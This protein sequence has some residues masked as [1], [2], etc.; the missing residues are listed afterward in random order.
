MIAA[1]TLSCLSQRDL[2]RGLLAGFAWAALF[3]A[4]ITAMQ[5]WQCGG[6]CL[7]EIATTG[8]LSLVCGILAIG[9]LAALGRR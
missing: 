5:A 3:T 8:A 9:P 7:S 4:G 2:R 6:I 1:T